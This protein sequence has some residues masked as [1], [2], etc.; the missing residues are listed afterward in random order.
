MKRKG[1]TLIELIIV[2]AVIAILASAIF[3]A[4]DPARRLHEARNSRRASDIVTILDAVKTYQ[5]DN[6]GTHYIEVIGLT[7]GRL[8]VVGTALGD[9]DISCAGSV[10]EA[11]CVDLSDMGSS[12]MAETPVDPKDGTL[13][14]T[15]YALQT[16]KGSDAITV[17]VCNPE[18]EGI[19][20]LGTPPDIDIT[21]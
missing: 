21:R 16:E 5:V 17:Y 20:G 9:C 13:E 2:I 10:A 8:Y 15:G 1:F 4:I 6:Q 19:G 12:Y 11:V 14:V 7:A 3:V 18:G